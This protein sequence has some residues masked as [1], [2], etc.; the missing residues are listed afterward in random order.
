VESG[1]NPEV[2]SIYNTQMT[3]ILQKYNPAD[4]K[5]DVEAQTTIH[6]LFQTIDDNAMISP[7]AKD[8]LKNGLWKRY[9]ITKRA[10]QPSI[11]KGKPSP[12][13]PTETP[14]VPASER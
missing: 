5:S 8:T 11:T 14:W 4:K 9:L 2:Q 1:I 13:R 6:A 12:P 7:Q 10:G 3:G